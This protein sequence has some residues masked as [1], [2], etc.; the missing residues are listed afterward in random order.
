MVIDDTPPTIDV[1]TSVE[2]SESVVP[3]LELFTFPSLASSAPQ[4]PPFPSLDLTVENDVVLDVTESVEDVSNVVPSDV[5]AES[6][7][8]KDVESEEQQSTKD[9]QL[10]LVDASSNEVQEFPHFTHLPNPHDR[11]KPLIRFRPQLVGETPQIQTTR[12]ILTTPTAP[13]D[14]TAISRMFKM[15]FVPFK[16]LV[17][18]IHVLT[19]FLK[20]STHKMSDYRKGTGV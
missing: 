17:Y 6:D 16:A 19:S 9:S 5:V 10:S 3:N 7:V 15:W 14:M 11:L 4:L 18:C 13:G 2:V 1:E 8:V 20:L 12:V